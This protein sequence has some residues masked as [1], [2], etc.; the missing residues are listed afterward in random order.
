[1]G[2]KKN[3]GSKAAAQAKE[4]VYLGTRVAVNGI[5]SPIMVVV[6]QRSG[7]MIRCQW[8]DQDVRLQEGTFRPEILIVVPPA[9]DVDPDA[10][11]ADAPKVEP[12][13]GAA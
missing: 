11:A 8:F 10:P 6:G 3:K 13:E 1:M 7:G 12:A 9:E 4:A 2:K 5:R